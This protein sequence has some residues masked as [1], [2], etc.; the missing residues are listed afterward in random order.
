MSQRIVFQWPN[1][2]SN[3]KVNPKLSFPG[4][5][6][7]WLAIGKQVPFFTVQSHCKTLA[8]WAIMKY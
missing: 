5:P 6:S 3:F 7:M 2:T 8:T 4:T 1:C